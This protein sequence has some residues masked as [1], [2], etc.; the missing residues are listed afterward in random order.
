MTSVV[1]PELGDQLSLDFRRTLAHSPLNKL[2]GAVTNT[3]DNIIQVQRAESV[4]GANHIYGGPDIMER[5]NQRSIKIK[6]KAFKCTEI[7]HR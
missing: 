6:D 3:T 2:P 1:G 7:C 4:I 5:I